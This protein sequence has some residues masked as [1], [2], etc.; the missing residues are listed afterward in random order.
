M[1]TVY[2]CI[3]YEHD[4]RL[5]ALAALVCILASFTALNL[6]HHVRKSAGMA[7]IIWLSIAALAIGFGIWAT[8][9]IAMLAFSPV[10]PIG[11]AADLTIVSLIVAIVL[12]G[13]GMWIAILPGVPS[14]A[15]AGGLLVGAG[16]AAMHYIGMAAF[17]VSGTITWDRPMVAASLGLGA[18]FG[19][20][21]LP[22][23][24][25]H[26]ALRWKLIGTS[27]LALAICSLHFTAMGAVEI[28]PDSTIALSPAVVPTHWLAP[29]VA[30]ASI[31][32]L[33]LCCA[34]LSLDL[35]ERSRSAETARIREL[36]DAAIEGLILCNG[37]VIVSANRSFSKLVGQG[38]EDICRQ[39][40]AAFIPEQDVR[41]KLL[42]R[43]SQSI[44][45]E[46]RCQDGSLIPVELISGTIMYSGHL[47]HVVAIRDL[48]ER[49]EAEAQIRFL[50][51]HDPLT[52]LANRASFSQ[53]LDHEIELHR[54]S[55]RQLAVLYLDLDRFKEV[56]DLY[57]HA[58]GDQLLQD[59][60]K[61]LSS[62]LNEH[63]MLARL[64]GDEFAIIVPGIKGPAQAERLAERILKSFTD[65]G[66]AEGLVSLI[67]VSI[68]IAKYPFDAEDCT[69]LLS[70]ADTALYR[71]KVEGKG[72]FRFFEPAME[73]EARER[74]AL[75]H[76]L[77]HAI[78]KG[79]LSLVYQ[80]QA[81]IGTGEV[82]GFEAL[83]RWNHPR[84][85]EVPPAVFIP[86]AE[87]SGLIL[88]IGEWVLREACL[89]AA[90]WTRPLNLAVN[91]SAVQLTSNGFAELVRAT[92]VE[93]RLPPERL[94]IEV[95]ETAL[96]RDPARAHQALKGLAALGIQIAID[97]FGTGYS[98]LSN[99][100]AFPFSKIKIDG[101]F[102][103]A[104]HT[105]PQ[106]ATIVRAVL[107][108]GHGLGLPIVAE[109]VETL[110]ELHFLEAEGCT[111]AQGYLL[112]HPAPIHDFRALT[113]SHVAPTPDLI[114]HGL[115]MG[116][117]RS[118]S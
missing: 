83:L 31:A 70:S 90:S 17:E 22:A 82:T 97:D 118:R 69:T 21:A 71:A 6:L 104:I 91:V 46:L 113:C 38:P 50:A 36:A 101:S 41:A 106:A 76:D 81:Q 109:G 100:R 20:V 49:K 63:Q 85:G 114:T 59:V 74:R 99:L 80:P 108:L 64:G 92:L 84:R 3:A 1:L 102:I 112:A 16:I 27:L 65:N 86:L 47:H 11:Y 55:G 110:D 12:T 2:N 67:S 94:E 30:C 53:E 73:D 111:Q 77:R 10:L 93:T 35:R 72:T 68:G 54:M 29:G 57:G 56:N 48:R 32:I 19:T 105:N 14:A 23:G 62:V 87:E 33:L 89:E 115:T 107:G 75:D 78:V 42:A 37:E 52:R 18:A 98:S 116:K 24:L 88:S 60:A 4:L 117:Q 40:F 103:Q 43:A 51:H 45:T 8:H 7:R 34:G 66:A 25:R 61:R 95:T 44:E 26:S 39:S 79:E 58:A 9:F 13:I 28:L 5:V 15:W 96:I